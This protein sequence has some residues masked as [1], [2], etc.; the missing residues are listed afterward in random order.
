MKNKEK[1]QF[2]SEIRHIPAKSD[3]QR[4]NQCIREPQV[5]IGDGYF[6]I[7]NQV[8][9]ERTDEQAYHQINVCQSLKI[10]FF[11]TIGSEIYFV[12]S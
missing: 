5:K 11:L 4:K 8:A 12:T 10:I 1:E 2:I 3:V 6:S 7:F 9:K